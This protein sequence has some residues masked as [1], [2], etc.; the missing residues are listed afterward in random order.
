[1]FS[2]RCYPHKMSLSIEED[3]HAKVKGHLSLIHAPGRSHVKD[4]LSNNNDPYATITALQSS[5]SLHMDRLDPALQFMDAMR[6][7]RRLLYNS[8]FVDMKEQLVSVLNSLN[9]KSLL[10]MLRE[11]IHF[12]AI[13]DLKELPI[14]IIEKLKSKIPENY[15]MFLAQKKFLKELPIEVRVKAW[16]LN[17]DMFLEHIRPACHSMFKLLASKAPGTAMMAKRE[18]IKEVNFLARS[19]DSSDKLFSYFANYCC[20]Q[21]KESKNG[22]WGAIVRNVLLGLED[23]KNK[24]S[25]IAKLHEL[26]WHLDQCR[27]IGRMDKNALMQVVQY[28]ITTIIQQYKT[29]ER[30][31][32]D[33]G[34]LQQLQ[35]VNKSQKYARGGIGSM[36]RNLQGQVKNSILRKTEQK[37]RRRPLTDELG[38]AQADP[39]LYEHYIRKPGDPE[40]AILDPLLEDAWQYMR[41]IDTDKVFWYPVMDEYAPGYSRRIIFPMSLQKMRENMD[42]KMYPSLDSFE[43]DVLRIF[44]NC[45]SFNGESS[46]F[47]KYAMKLNKLWKSRRDILMD[48]LRNPALPPPPSMN[49]MMA[50]DVSSNT[51]SSSVKT[52]KQKKMRSVNDDEDDDEEA[53]FTGDIPLAPNQATRFPY[54]I[55]SAKIKAITADSEKGWKKEASRALMDLAWQH[56]RDLDREGIFANPVTDLVAPG[57][58]KFIST[59]MDM[60]TIKLKMSKK[61]YKTL[62]DFD[63]DVSLML[64]NCFS[65]NELQKT[66]TVYLVGEMLHRAWK[67]L[68]KNLD[69]MVAEKGTLSTEGDSH[70]SPPSA[71]ASSSSAIVP[72]STDIDTVMVVKTKEEESLLSKQQTTAETAVVSNND[73]ANEEVFQSAPTAPVEVEVKVKAAKVQTKEDAVVVDDVVAQSEK[74]KVESGNNGV[75]IEEGPGVAEPT[76][77]RMKIESI[78]K[79][80]VKSTLKTAQ[81][82]LPPPSESSTMDVVTTNTTSTSEESKVQFEAAKPVVKA[83]TCAPPRKQ[84]K[85][86][87]PAGVTE[88][89]LAMFRSSQ[90]AIA[91]INIAHSQSVEAS[92]EPGSFSITKF[93]SSGISSG[94]ASKNTSTT[95]GISLV[96]RLFQI[97]AIVSDNRLSWMML[98]LRDPG[99]QRWIIKLFA[100]QINE[101]LVDIFAKEKLKLGNITSTRHPKASFPSALKHALPYDDQLCRL[102]CQLCQL[103]WDYDDGIASVDASL[104]RCDIPEMMMSALLKKQEPLYKKLEELEGKIESMKAATDATA[105]EELA[106]EVESFDK[107]KLEWENKTGEEYPSSV[108]QQEDQKMDTQENEEKN[109]M[110]QAK[111]T[112]IET[113]FKAIVAFPE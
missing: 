47:T 100:A 98:I 86:F 37:S 40:Q 73:Q 32:K 107:M 92:K 57:Y 39:R 108:P 97:P 87:L 43:K 6:I 68:K 111:K 18:D 25:S 76:H 53:E 55:A 84:T 94:F 34:V 50:A 96:Q 83:A 1:M 54:I 77:K 72:P 19:I 66:G 103:Q 99:I 63:K 62:S 109:E 90:A 78:E 28:V 104:L 29:A 69:K 80:E 64:S 95:S 44:R 16:S 52:K 23:N 79:G 36:K 74:E 112:L 85:S 65:Y 110:Q 5:L 49:S 56:L 35:P 10:V 26:A 20:E 42:K 67:D 8:V 4:S 2:S 11:T 31:M 22:L 7:P 71:S 21:A 106:K 59:P 58:S 89:Q 45:R 38:N 12:M 88:P 48:R 41:N 101:L 14:S 51:A 33:A 91:V 9:E 70:G 75:G 61:K 113:L 13:D 81:A 30:M 93:G 46:V 27:R 102:C 3:V 17:E 15:L 105:V 24:I 82:A 60:S